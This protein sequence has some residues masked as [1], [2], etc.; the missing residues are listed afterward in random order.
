MN[1]EHVLVVGG[2][3]MLS[4][5]SLWLNKKG[6]TVVVIGRHKEKYR[7]MVKQAKEPKRMFS[8][9]VDYHDDILFENKVEETIRRNGPFS[10]IIAWVHSSAS[11]VIPTLMNIQNIYSQGNDFH[12]YHI[13][14]S[15]S[16]F[17]NMSLN[18]PKRCNYYEVFLGFKI[19]NNH[20]RWL[21]HKEISQGVKDVIQHRRKHTIVGQIEPWAK[22]PHH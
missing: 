5:V 14:S 17:D 10:H 9:A 3:G 16:Y 1:R 12:F 7:Q 11:N 8:I 22:R 19:I 13:K 15:A 6:Y 2:T 18:I 21:T 4:E 20:S